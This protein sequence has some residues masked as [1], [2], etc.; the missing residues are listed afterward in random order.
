MW[1]VFGSTLYPLGWWLHAFSRFNTTSANSAEPLVVCLTL[2]P[3]SPLLLFKPY[4]SSSCTASLLSTQFSSYDFSLFMVL[5]ASWLLLIPCFHIFLDFVPPFPLM[6]QVIL[7]SSFPRIKIQFVYQSP[8]S[9]VS[10]LGRALLKL[11]HR[12]LAMGQLLI[13]RLIIYG[14]DNGFCVTQLLLWNNNNN[15]NKTLQSLSDI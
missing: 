12:S 13:P 4:A 2:H 6:T 14:L 7:Q 1:L 15:N 10:L 9:E 5:I 11:P 3:D 8:L